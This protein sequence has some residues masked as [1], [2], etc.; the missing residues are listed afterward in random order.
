M[1]AA[2]CYCFRQLVI[3][4][5][6]AV[7]ANSANELCRS[8]GPTV[9]FSFTN[10]IIT[11]ATNFAKRWLSYYRSQH[12]DLCLTVLYTARPHSR[13]IPLPS[14]NGRR[15]RKVCGAPPSPSQF[16]NAAVAAIFGARW[17][18]QPTFERNWTGHRGE[19]SG[20]AYVLCVM[21]SVG[22]ISVS[23]PHVRGHAPCVPLDHG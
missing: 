5:Q 4:A 13:L 19:I 8:N 7:W 10:V 3:C 17:I 15:R 2:D 23:E 20:I 14:E 11:C 12:L 1:K 16:K 18:F 21:M 9:M 6:C 22:G